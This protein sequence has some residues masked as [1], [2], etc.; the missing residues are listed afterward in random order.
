MKALKSTLAAIAVVVLA[1]VAFLGCGA[2]PM[3]SKLTLEN[4]D[5]ITETETTYEEVV[6]LF[7][8]PQADEDFADGDGTAVWNNKKGTKTVTLTFVDN[9]VTEKDQE[10]LE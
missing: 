4:Y 6:E 3:D 8:E 5:Q 9:I 1:S 2:D 10:G 7:G